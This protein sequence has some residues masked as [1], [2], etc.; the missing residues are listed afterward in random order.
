MKLED[1]NPTRGHENAV[2]VGC[3]E[4][5]EPI[6]RDLRSNE[7]SIGKLEIETRDGA[8]GVNAQ[9]CRGDAGFAI[10]VCGEVELVWSYKD[11]DLSF[12]GLVVGGGDLNISELDIA[13]ERAAVECVDLA[14]EL[15]DEFCFWCV[16]DFAWG[17]DL[18]DLAAAHDDDTIGY[19]KSFFLI[20]CDEDAGDMK[21]VVEAPDPLSEFGADFCIEC[22]ERL[23]E[24]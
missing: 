23:V 8:C 11:L 24:E 18:F 9:D 20:V 13:S 21:F 1:V 5:C 2:S 14:E 3:S 15:H 10:G 16:V 17:A 12:A 7:F 22:A 6:L 19:F 4:C